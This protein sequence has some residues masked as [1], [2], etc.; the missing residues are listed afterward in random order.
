MKVKAGTLTKK[1]NKTDKHL[2]KL[3]M[4]KGEKGQMNNYKKESSL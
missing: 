1:I 3:V 4:K 2:T